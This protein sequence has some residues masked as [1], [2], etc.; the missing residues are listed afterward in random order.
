VLA[1]FSADER[2]LMNKLRLEDLGSERRGEIL[3]LTFAARRQWVIN[4]MPPFSDFIM[5]FPQVKCVG[6]LVGNFDA[7]L[8]PT[9]FSCMRN[10]CLMAL[11]LGLPRWVGTRKVKL[12][13]ILLKQEIVSGS[14]ISWAICK[15]ALRSRQVTTP[16]SH[17]SV[18]TGRML[19]QQC[20]S[21]EGTQVY[22]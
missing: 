19:N 22:A 20:Q 11:C 17:Y 7:S 3:E 12:N 16:A 5:K 4:S 15:S 9:N 10:T 8:L 14:G 6:S 2:A 18:F 1:P 13:W 21:T